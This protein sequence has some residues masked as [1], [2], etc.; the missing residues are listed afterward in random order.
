MRLLVRPP[1]SDSH[2]R[3]RERENGTRVTE[4]NY[5]PNTCTCRVLFAAK[6]TA[7]GA[8]VPFYCMKRI[9]LVG[10]F[11]AVDACIV[12]QGNLTFS[13][14][15]APFMANSVMIS[16]PGYFAFSACWTTSRLARSSPLQRWLSAA[17]FMP[18]SY[19]NSGVAKKRS[20]TTA[21]R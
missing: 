1:N 20:S 13:A 7:V 16:E 18:P 12:F 19:S 2:R 21:P 6:D 10:S 11:L 17:S 4:I 5:S 8:V 14:I 15:P 9:F 3:Q